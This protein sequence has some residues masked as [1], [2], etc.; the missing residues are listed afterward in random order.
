[1][2]F[3]EPTMALVSC[4][5]CSTN[6]QQGGYP[7]WVIIVCICFFPVGLLALLAGKKPSTCGSCGHTFQS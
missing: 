5:K 6:T 2:D 4:P 7:V 1:M 3:L